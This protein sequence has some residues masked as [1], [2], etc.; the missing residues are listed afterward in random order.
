MSTPAARPPGA[1]SIRRLFVLSVA[2]RY[3]TTVVQFAATLVITRLLNPEEVGI[4]SVA[5]SIVALIHTV[6]NF[7]MAQY[8]VQEK[9]LTRPRFRTAV[10][11]TLTISGTFAVALWWGA[12]LMSSFYG[13]PALIPALQVLAVS[14][15]IG[16]LYA[17][18]ASKLEREMDFVTLLKIGSVMALTTAVMSVG[19]A[20]LGASYMAMVW[21]SVLGNLAAL[22]LLM[23]YRW[24]DVFTTPSFSGWRDVLSFGVKA[25]GVSI[26]SMLGVQAALLIMPRYLGFA[27]AGLYGRGHGLVSLFT[28]DVMGTVYRVLVPEFA[29]I[30]RSG[31]DLR[32]RYLQSVTYVTGLAWP[33]YA[34]MALTAE[35]VI[36]AMFGPAWAEAA[37]VTRVLCLA[38]AVHTISSTS[39]QVIIG[40][41]GIGKI[42]AGELIQQPLRVVLVF[43][44]AQWGMVEVA[45][46][47]VA[48]MMVAAILYFSRV[49]SLIDISILDVVRATRL[50]AAVTFWTIVPVGAVWYALGD[51]GRGL[52]FQ[53][54]VVA[55]TASLGWVCAI[56]VT[57]HPFKAELQRL[58]PW[59]VAGGL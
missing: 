20:F 49:F 7:G 10:A 50:S 33:F 41:G 9:E 51:W 29:H 12:R 58:D 6:R 8:I 16:P 53:V 26:L 27:A 46:A 14:L 23:T 37:T 38:H 17:P 43:M 24:R 35:P 59:K 54:A 56:F 47:E 25:T 5:L 39:T 18:A 3:L 21:G 19:L 31:G 22:L 48:A 57:G 15:L 36:V 1:A 4:F 32:G 40:L 45:W 34:V 42:L 2:E 44:G 11:V 55:L 13:E 28:R 52:G 30:H